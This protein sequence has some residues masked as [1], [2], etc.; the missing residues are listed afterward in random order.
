MHI[1]RLVLFVTLVSCGAHKQFNESQSGISDRKEV[2]KDD[3]LQGQMEDAIRSEDLARI[4][5]LIDDGQ[6][7][8][9][10]LKSGKTLLT[11]ACAAGKWKSVKKLIELNADI[12]LKD[13][14]NKNIH[15]YA[16]NSPQLRRILDPN[17][18]IV[19][20]NKIL[21]AIKNKKTVQ[22]KKYLEEEIP[23]LNFILDLT[24]H[25]ANIEEA[26]IGQTLLTWL[27]LKK[28]ELMVRTITLVKYGVNPNLKN[29]NGDSPLAL[30]KKLK[31]TNIEIHLTKLG[32]YE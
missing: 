2:R 27:I 23:D 30:A 15:D 10:E 24:N 22:L 14:H 17:L 32:A 16:I 26:D 20:Q 11:E 19:L 18:E 9:S 3:S 29:K 12:N 7:I 13:K 4:E 5:K 1:F 6:S 31:L 21:D 8:N 25:A 28:N